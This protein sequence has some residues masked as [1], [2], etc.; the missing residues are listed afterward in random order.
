MCRCRFSHIGEKDKLLRLKPSVGTAPTFAPSTAP[1]F[2]SWSAVVS[3]SQCHGRPKRWRWL[4][5]WLQSTLDPRPV[6]CSG[7]QSFDCRSRVWCLAWGEDYDVGR[8][9]NPP[10]RACPKKCLL[11][12]KRAQSINPQ[13]NYNTTETCQCSDY[14]LLKAWCVI[15]AA[16]IGGA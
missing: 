6:P 7:M 8:L 11:L 13:R 4:W 16:S 1:H 3:R 15:A 10:R 12:H 5:L 14:C 2:S 9:V